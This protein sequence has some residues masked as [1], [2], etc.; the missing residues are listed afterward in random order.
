[1]ACGGHNNHK[2]HPACLELQKVYYTITISTFINPVDPKGKRT[3]CSRKAD[4]SK[5]GK[6]HLK[7][8]VIITNVVTKFMMFGFGQMKFSAYG[9][10][11]WYAHVWMV[12]WKDSEKM[13]GRK[14]VWFQQGLIIATSDQ[15]V[16]SIHCMIGSNSWRWGSVTRLLYASWYTWPNKASPWTPSGLVYD[17]SGLWTSIRRLSCVIIVR[18]CNNIK[19][20][21]TKLN[22]MT[23]HEGPAWHC[24]GAPRRQ[25]LCGV[26]HHY[27]QSL[28]IS[29][30]RLP[31]LRLKGRS[32]LH[33][34]ERAHVKIAFNA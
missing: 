6:H 32:P 31:I 4:V 33:I 2:V 18:F 21:G 26:I 22:V 14:H 15:T 11:P 25:Q 30:T 20:C 28:H 16:Q 10:N 5:W 9:R 24:N 29:A 8:R 19:S 23:S 3:F 12:C 13:A 34:A 27:K 7:L 1:M 17:N